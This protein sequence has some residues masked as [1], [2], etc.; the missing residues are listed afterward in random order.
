MRRSL[1]SSP[2]S[3]LWHFSISSA[4]A[5]FLVALAVV[6][7]FFLIHQK[8]VENMSA[9][10]ELINHVIIESSLTLHSNALDQ[11]EAGARA[12]MELKEF[13]SVTVLNDVGDKI[14]ELG[15]P[16][17]PNQLSK[18]FTDTKRWKEDQTLFISQQINQAE[19]DALWVVSTINLTRGALINL[20]FVITLILVVFGILVFSIIFYRKI[21]S[22]IFFPLEFL[23]ESLSK[24]NKM[25]EM[26][27]I[28]LRKCGIYEELIQHLNESFSI[29]IEKEMDFKKNVDSTAQEL[30]E[31]LET[32][33][34]HNIDLDMARKNAVELNKLKSEFL[35]KISDDLYSPLA[36]ILDFSELLSK[37]KISELQRDYI[38]TIEQSIKGLIVIVNDI[39]D[40][41]RLESGT[42][43]IDKRP[44]SIRR[45]IEECL[46]LQSA[47]ALQE[48][49]T[50]YNTVDQDV[51][52]S[53][54]GDPIRIQQV[55]SNLVSNAIKFDQTSF[56]EVRAKNVNQ[57][58]EFSLVR[59]EIITDGECPK[60]FFDWNNDIEQSKQKT[61]AGTGLGLSIARGIAQHMR[62]RIEFEIMSDTCAFIVHLNLPVSKDQESPRNVIESDR[63]VT[64]LV[65][66]NKDAGHHEISSRLYELGIRNQRA[67]AFSD[68]IS[69]A[70]KIKTDAKLHQQNNQIAVIEAQTSQQSLDK[71]VLTETLKAL[72]EELNI[73]TIV[74]SPAGQYDQLKKITKDIDTDI[75]QRPILTS[76]FKKCILDK[77]GVVSLVGESKSILEASRHSSIKVLLVDDN[78]TNLKLASAMLSEFGT[79]IHTADSGKTAL[80]A[81]RSQSFDIVFMD[82]QLPDISGADATKKIRA[83]E[84]SS[85]SK[86]RTPIIALTAQDINDEKSALLLAGLDDIIGKPLTFD[87]IHSIIE[88]WIGSTKA[89]AQSK[90]RIAHESSNSASEPP[91]NAIEKTTDSDEIAD[92]T[93][94]PVNISDCIQLAKGDPQLA[95]EMLSMLIDSLDEEKSRIDEA[96]QNS[97]LEQ[98]YNHVHR[99]HGACCYCGVPK[100]KQISKQIDKQLRQNNTESLET[101]V[102]RMLD[103][104]K[105]LCDW[106]SQH[107]LK[108]IFDI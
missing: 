68:I 66:S 31:S 102:S 30:R 23:N 28:I 12:M 52:H 26:A 14:F 67:H 56:V 50:L 24:K 17:Q 108:T 59:I 80:E 105:E 10:S 19:G 21:N 84:Q 32:V 29:Q 13:N 97:N 83:Y 78:P 1:A 42:L 60:S 4:G 100:L 81:F 75:I 47:N 38:S 53:L 92:T 39:H 6:T 88:R 37:T 62:G 18:P 54:L 33:E 16:I 77:L 90:P 87:D 9:R 35:K 64:A 96:M 27:P 89:T 74:L 7:T 46:T 43:N 69:L 51:P 95:F 61:Y 91:S 36:G 48:G 20:Q 57:T 65:Y 41:S 106:S 98:L 45:T 22:D 76:K 82:I 25:R 70:K 55:F 93:A 49:I 79:E 58:N 3:Q 71:I 63:N 103:A 44:V 94:I 5:L 86:N 15:E 40:F 73:P 11:L 99:I 72:E 101:H 104:M 107:D 2:N 85:T 8:K 34:I